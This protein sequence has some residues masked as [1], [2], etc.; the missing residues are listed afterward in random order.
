MNFNPVW[1]NGPASTFTS[2][3]PPSSA[4]GNSLSTRQPNRQA[5][6]DLA[7][8]RHA[9]DERQSDPSRLGDQFRI[10][11]GRDAELRS[12]LF[13]R[14]QI[15]KRQDRARSNQQIGRS[16]EK[17]PITSAAAGVRNVISAIGKPPAA[18]ASASGSAISSAIHGHNR[19]DAQS[20]NRREHIFR[21]VVTFD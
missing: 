15:V 5:A 16:R 18:K 10:Q 3:G 17:R 20:S 6:L 11:A 19:H 1:P 14:V 12:G 9:R 7:G 4:A 8:R 21:H 13:R 2:G